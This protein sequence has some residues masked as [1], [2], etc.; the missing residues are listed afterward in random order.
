[1]DPLV[2]GN[3]VPG[4]ALQRAIVHRVFKIALLLKGFN[5]CAEI[6][7]A[8]GFFFF[9]KE[10]IY[11]SLMVLAGRG[12]AGISEHFATGYLVREAYDF[13][14]AKYFLAFYFLFYGLVNIFLVISLL[15]GKLWAYPVSIIATCFFILYL[16]YRLFLYHSGLLLFFT[17]ID[18]ALVILTWLEY[19]GIKEEVVKN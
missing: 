5:G 11:D 12:T 17:L 3:V 1:M 2:S 19:Q 8:I 9:K 7:I 14:S 13:S 15:R 16:A 10:T 4:K 6:V 18:I